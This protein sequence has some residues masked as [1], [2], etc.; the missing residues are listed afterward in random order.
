MALR[1][2][3]AAAA[4]QVVSGKTVINHYDGTND[5]IKITK[6]DDSETYFKIDATGA[7]YELGLTGSTI[8]IKGAAYTTSDRRLKDDITD[9]DDA[10]AAV[11]GLRGV[12]YS[13]VKEAPG[14]DGN[15]RRFLGFLAQEVEDVLPELVSTDAE[16]TKSVN[17]CVEIKILRRVHAI[18]AT[19]ARWRGDPGSSLLERA[20]TAASSP[21]NDLVKNSRVHPTHWLISTQVNYVGVVPVLVE[22][23]KEERAARQALA[24][25]LDAV[26]A[27]LAALDTIIES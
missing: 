10:T 21:R 22:A 15:K 19:P 13:W 25:R 1:A 9:L 17:Y 18:D 2:L 7:N 24:D 11:E 8:N 14:A 5:L 4:L 6:D 27:R 23:L 26:E 3:L 12:R 20:R 16:G